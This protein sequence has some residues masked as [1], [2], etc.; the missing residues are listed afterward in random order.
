MG[1]SCARYGFGEVCP[2][3]VLMGKGCPGA[4]CLGKRVENLEEE[5]KGNGI[6]GSKFK[7]VDVGVR[8]RKAHRWG[9][10]RVCDLE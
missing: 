9:C 1:L 6:P 4:G 3:Q 5:C 2:G 7:P 10:P 8:D